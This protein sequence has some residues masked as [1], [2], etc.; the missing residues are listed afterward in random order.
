M[1]FWFGGGNSRWFGDLV[2]GLGLLAFLAGVL[3]L[4]VTYVVLGVV[5]ILLAGRPRR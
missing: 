3:T 2:A 5:L 1:I 4:D